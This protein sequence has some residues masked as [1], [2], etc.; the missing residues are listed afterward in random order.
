MH[1]LHIIYHIESRRFEMADMFT[2]YY[3]FLIMIVWF[4]VGIV[5]SRM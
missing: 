3:P 4:V 2:G 1:I 5:G